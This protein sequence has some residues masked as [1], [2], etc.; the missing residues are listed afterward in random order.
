MSLFLETTKCQQLF[1]YRWAFVPISSLPSL[2][3]IWF[4]LSLHGA[5]ACCYNWY[6][7]IYAASLCP[8]DTI[9]LY[10]STVLVL[11][12]FLHPLSQWLL[13]FERKKYKDIPFI[14]GHFIVT[15]SLHLDQLVAFLCVNWHPLLLI[16]PSLMRDET[17]I[18]LWV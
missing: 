9:S 12:V 15:Y 18:Y 6:E 2:C 4:G 16:E 1:G 14:A 8:E 5:C 10:L 7:F 3:W 11:A 13:N 17:C